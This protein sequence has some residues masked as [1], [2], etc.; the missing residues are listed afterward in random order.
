MK[1]VG[2][3]LREANEKR[4]II[5]ERKMFEKLK[6]SENSKCQT[7]SNPH[8]VHFRD[9][10]ISNIPLLSSNCYFKYIN[11]RKSNA[12]MNLLLKMFNKL[13]KC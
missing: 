1:I 3:G 10:S 5:I 8:F 4:E 9:I 13:R 12:S 7:L 2:K 6:M 11:C